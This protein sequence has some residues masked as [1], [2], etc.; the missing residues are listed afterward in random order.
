MDFQSQQEARVCRRRRFG[1]VNLTEKRV[2]IKL[3]GDAKESYMKLKKM[4]EE[5][6]KKGI[7]N[8]FN[9]TLFR[10]IENKI[11][12]LKRE[13]DSGIHIPKNKI[14]KKYLLKYDVTN[15]W[16]VNISGGWRIIYTIKQPQR[17]NTEVEILLI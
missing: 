9:Q 6:H 12:I 7:E 5:E 13:Y 8:S 17:D 15:L 2:S 3:L 11:S 1:G 10:S 16:K 4:I 14:G